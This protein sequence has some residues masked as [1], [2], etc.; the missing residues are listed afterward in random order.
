MISLKE[1]NQ[2]SDCFSHQF[3]KMST[4]SWVRDQLV[5]TLNFTDN[6]NYMAEFLTNLAMTTASPDDLVDQVR[7]K[8][9]IDVNDSK[10]ASFLRELWNRIPRA[11]PQYNLDQIAAQENT[12]LNESKRYRLV[13]IDEEEN[14][15]TESLSPKKAKLLNHNSEGLRKA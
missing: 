3:E 12:I 10:V 15:V 4:D 8:Q 2:H 7:A 5:E 14:Q 11:A 9:T 13:E 1:T 6:D